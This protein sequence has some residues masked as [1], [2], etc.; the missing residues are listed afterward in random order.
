MQYQNSST[1]RCCYRYYHYHYYWYYRHCHAHVVSLLFM[2]LLLLRWLLSRLSRLLWPLSSLTS[3]LTST[4]HG[5]LHHTK[6]ACLRHQVGLVFLGT[7]ATLHPLALRACAFI[8]GT[9]AKCLSATLRCHVP[10]I[11][12]RCNSKCK[13]EKPVYIYISGACRSL[14]LLKRKLVKGST[15]R[16][17]RRGGRET[18]YSFFCRLRSHANRG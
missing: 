5:L 18:R 6:P 2:L 1:T 13:W 3:V 8:Y 11:Y 12:K 9:L 10:L 7:K 16:D 14:V 17:S 15:R 4:G